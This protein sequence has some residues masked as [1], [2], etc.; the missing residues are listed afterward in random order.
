MTDRIL[1]FAREA[2]TAAAR[3][4]RHLPGAEIIAVTEPEGLA[5]ALARDPMAAFT[6]NSPD[7][8][9]EAHQAVLHHPSVA[10][11]QVGGS[12]Y[13]HLGPLEGVTKRIT[14]CAGVLAPF[15]AET[16]VGALLA[17]DHGLI[18]Y[19]DRQRDETWAPRPFRPLMGQTLLIVGAG[20]IGG[21]F[22][23]RAAGLGMRVIALRRSG[24][25]VEG[26]AETRPPDALTESLAEADAVS[27][28]L[29]LT[30]ETAGICDAGFFAAMRPGA[31]FLNTAR[32][33]HVVE[34]DLIAAL[35]SGHLAGAYLDVMR[36]EPLAKGDPLWAAPNLLLSPHAADG[37]SDW[38]ERFTDRFVANVM[39]RAAGEPMLGVV[40]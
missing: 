34:P 33:G 8:P 3:A 17:L 28:H 38:V 2:E 31:L 18:H 15:L 39:A 40:L 32:G 5:A 23:K 14:N 21:E 26:A 19:R 4:A 22:A 29:R 13:E 36:T 27:L 11:L 12:G 9:N 35:A 30:P 20:A 16:C 1:I 10:W 37:V 24:Q 25:P 7:L 6:I